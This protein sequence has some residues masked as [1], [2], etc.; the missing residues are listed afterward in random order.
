MCKLRDIEQNERK[1]VKKFPGHICKLVYYV[2]LF[3]EAC[4]QASSKMRAN[5]EIYFRIEW[6]NLTETF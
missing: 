2:K 4:G 5:A 6:K 1:K 3:D